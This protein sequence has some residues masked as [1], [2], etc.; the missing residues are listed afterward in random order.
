MNRKPA[1]G[2]QQERGRNDLGRN[3]LP[4]PAPKRLLEGGKTI[5]SWDGIAGLRCA[6]AIPEDPATGEP[7][8]VEELGTMTEPMS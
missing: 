5:R 7:R 3:A 1:P 2:D 4:A 8:H 6:R